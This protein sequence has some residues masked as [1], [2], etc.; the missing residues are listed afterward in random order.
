[1][2]AWRRVVKSC[3]DFAVADQKTSSLL[4]FPGRS[5]DVGFCSLLAGR[6][7]G[8]VRT[9]G[10]LRACRAKPYILSFRCNRRRRRRRRRP[11]SPTRN[12]EPGTKYTE[13]TDENIST[14]CDIITAA[15][16]RDEIRWEALFQIDT[17]SR[18]PNSG[19]TAA[20]NS[21][22]RRWCA[23]F[24]QLGKDQKKQNLKQLE[25]NRSQLE[26]VHGTR[27]AA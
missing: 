4:P 16:A 13:D 11:P 18:H 1:M 10:T 23:F 14:L 17:K 2:F 21:V 9:L 24:F 19:N 8:T 20:A 3:C 25:Q 5:N 6:S 26:V 7:P 12:P 22:C 15:T 27:N